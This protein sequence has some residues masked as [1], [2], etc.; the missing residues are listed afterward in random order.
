MRTI[1][2]N[3]EWTL[4][5]GEQ[6]SA[7]RPDEDFFGSLPAIPALVPGNVELDLMRAGVLPD[8]YIGNNIRRAKDIETWA[9][10]YT[11]T[12]PRPEFLEGER[13]FLC[14]GGVDCIADY[15]L[16]GI[17]IYDSANALIKAVLDK[18]VCGIIYKYDSA[19]A[20]I[21]HCLDVTDELIDGENEITIRIY[22]ALY[23]A[24]DYPVEAACFALAG[25][26]EALHIRKAPH[27]YG[28]D[29]MPRCVSAGL[30]R[31]V[32][33]E[34]RPAS[35]IA[36]VYLAA[37]A[38]KD[39]PKVGKSAQMRLVFD[40]TLPNPD[41]RGIT[42]EL[43]G[44]CG[45][46]A[47]SHTERLMFPKGICDF[48][49]DNPMLWW[50]NGYGVPNLYDVTITLKRNGAVIDEI[51]RSV[52]I[53][54]VRLERS[55][56]TDGR[57]GCFQFYVN[58]VPVYCKGSNWVPLDMLH[59]RDSERYETALS[60]FSDTHCN[61]LRTWGGNVYEDNAFFEQCD[62]RGIMVWQDFSF[63]C[64]IYPQNEE[65]LCRVHDEVV[66]IVRKLRGHCSIILWSG[67]NECDVVGY[68]RSGLDPAKN[69]LTRR[70]IPDALAAHDPFRPYLPSSPYLSEEAFRCGDVSIAPEQ[71]LWGP[72]DYYKS[73]FYRN[74][75]AHF[76]SETG[77]HG[78]TDKSSIERFISPG[79]LWPPEDND[80]WI[81]HCTDPVGFDGP[82][83]YRVALMSN[84][85]AEL[86]G[87]V[88]K[89]M[90]DFILASQ[91]SQ[92]EAKKSF[93][94]HARIAPHMTGLIWWNMLDGWPQFSD[95]VV[96]YYLQKKLAYHYIKR[97]Q[98]HICLMMDDPSDW[99]CNLYAVNDTLCE[100]RG[101]YI[102]TEVQSGEKVD[103]GE[104]CADANCATL[105]SRIRVS[106][107]AH[108]LYLIH[109]EMG[110]ERYKNHYILGMPP[111]ELST[112]KQWLKYILED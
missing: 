30:W 107:G 85:T 7:I 18:G 105:L 14:F 109:W 64:A 58:N 110:G 61:I 88:P 1:S 68:F 65:F 79:K 55:D 92:A 72:R 57:S 84:Q 54:T 29:I 43:N 70:V 111:F 91:I 37:L 87:C 11:R 28:W 27:V 26:Y 4:S 103:S 76:V 75:P 44:V 25:G 51:K 49:I 66:S 19:N 112:Y 21:E 73:G 9:F 100:Q 60:M 42:L 83:A 23:A 74:S 10:S 17:F 41:T 38:L 89:D 69:Q 32:T 71:H 93:I 47:F 48:T 82:Y 90:D 67:D 99:H 108:K 62:R 86:F 24:C 8:L 12:F 3:G 77:Y 96:D 39:T 40:I 31:D 56:V 50:P 59:S 102:V 20:L 81:T 15:Y 97:S 95:A 52:G 35:Y 106:H 45:G 33:I 63:A 94:E 101:S 2:L 5:Y 34:V 98:Q 104:F 78:C 36:D 46:S 6:P 16:N 80:E 22:S 53:R 13:V